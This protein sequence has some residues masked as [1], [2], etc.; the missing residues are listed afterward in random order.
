MWNPYPDQSDLDLD[1]DLNFATA[2]FPRVIL[3]RWTGV[4]DD[5]L[6]FLWIAGDHPVWECLSRVPAASCFFSCFI[7]LLQVTRSCFWGDSS[8]FAIPLIFGS[9]QIF[10][11]SSSCFFFWFIQRS[12]LWLSFPHRSSSRALRLRTYAASLVPDWI[13]SHH[14]AWRIIP[15]PLA[16]FQTPASC[17]NADL[18]YPETVVSGLMERLQFWFWLKSLR[19]SYSERRGC[20]KSVRF[21]RSGSEFVALYFLVNCQRLCLRE[22]CLKIVALLWGAI[23]PEGGCW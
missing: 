21:E 16:N 17:K 4:V 15:S 1:W 5:G 2:Q 6:A 22:I 13:P 10:P 9:F 14:M 7:F 18:D 8:F 3:Y 23:Y 11:R 12:P 19:F 20:E